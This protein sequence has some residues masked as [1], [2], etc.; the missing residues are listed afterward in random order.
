MSQLPAA[1]SCI[2]LHVKVLDLEPPSSTR[3]LYRLDSDSVDLRVGTKT[4]KFLV[5]KR[6][7][8]VSWWSFPERRTW[9]SIFG[10]PLVTKPLVSRSFWSF[11]PL[12]P[13]RVVTWKIQKRRWVPDGRRNTSFSDAPG[14]ASLS[15]VTVARAPAKRRV[16]HFSRS[17]ARKL[18]GLS[19]CLV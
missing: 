14:A 9:H 13:R 17:S 12:R 19:N 15:Y 6:S 16:Q 8:K 1:S 11:L 4:W 2:Q 10:K 18:E 7:K 5:Q 3:R